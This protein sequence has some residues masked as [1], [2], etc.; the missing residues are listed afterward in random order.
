M[1]IGRRCCGPR[2]RRLTLRG[3]RSWHDQGRRRPV[4]CLAQCWVAA[5]CRVKRQHSP[6]PSTPAKAD[7]FWG[8]A[9][10]DQPWAR[11]YAARKT[12]SHSPGKAE[13]L[14]NPGCLGPRAWQDLGWV[15][16][17]TR[18]IA[19][20]TDSSGHCPGLLHQGEAVLGC[21]PAPRNL[22]GERYVLADQLLDTHTA[23]FRPGLPGNDVA[24]R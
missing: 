15:W 8:L 11:S 18:H 6:K 24:G 7:W 13:P 19:D 1:A 2:S 4:P 3:V 5:R 17:M 12:Q 22:F 23:D 14:Q 20:R 21:G 10:T 16:Y 9:T